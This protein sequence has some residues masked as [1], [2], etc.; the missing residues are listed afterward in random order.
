MR[1]VFRWELF[2][3]ATDIRKKAS[4]NALN[5]QKAITVINFSEGGPCANIPERFSFHDFFDDKNARDPAATHEKLVW[6]LAGILFDEIT[7]PDE[8]QKVPNAVDRLRK[9]ELSDF[10]QKLV[11]SASAQQVAMARSN[12]EK[13][14]ASL[15][16]HRVADAC[17]H[18]LNGKNFHLATL[19]A[20]IGKDS[21]RKDIREQLS[22]WQKQRVLP[23]FSQPIRAIY[24]ILAGNVGVCDGSKGAPIEDRID[25]FIISQR[26]G[27]DWR[28]AFGLRLWY[29]TLATEE[30]GTAVEKFAYDL[31][32]DLETS[33][34]QAWYVEQ[35]IPTLWEDAGVN[36]RED[37]LWGL[38]RLH[39][40]ED[41]DLEAIIRPEN[42]QLSPVDMR[43]SWQLSRALTSSG[44]VHYSE[45]ADMKADQLTLSFASQL[46]NE[47]SWLD[48]VFVLL[49]L[50]CETARAK[51]IQN[52]L[53]QQAGRIGSADSQAFTILTQTY[54]IP[55]P[56]IWEAKALYLR[57]VKKDATGEVEC[58]IAAGSFE[59][60]HRT[61]AKEVAPRTVIECD[62]D[63]MRALLH[64]FHG[65]EEGIS[66]WH[67]GG[68]I[69]CD[70]LELLDSQKK[71]TA[72]SNVVLNRLLAGLPAMMEE[73][74]H[75]E[76]ME[77]VAIAT[78]SET[79][80]KAVVEMGK[81]G[82]VG[83]RYLS[84][85]EL[86]LTRDAEEGPP[87]NPS[88]SFDGG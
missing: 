71:A 36:D 61:F 25:S 38:L 9:D 82:E 13:A 2:Y 37:L 46:I 35:K 27:L 55:A 24:E 69:Y 22:E 15:S 74:R 41:A 47:G 30:L 51:S 65:R 84:N 73:S 81:N 40:F 20:L 56:W 11:D 68:E 52:L 88:P 42:S 72:V 66:E 48:A 78:M 63:T 70:F 44:V 19:V 86:M 53:A 60:A 76:F 79:V 59:E 45:D 57:S 33:K 62:Y 10:W 32:Q 26:F 18:L 67:L 87:Q 23:E 29:G 7:V 31:A 28:Q 14:I 3:R 50:S 77:R 58:L 6:Q 83:Q 39:T 1:L 5:K 17:G 64:G 80:A 54:K 12:E 34:P 8:L 16:G 85:P 43:L 49:H 4:A 75:P 21:N